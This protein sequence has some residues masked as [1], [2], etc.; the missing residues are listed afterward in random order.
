MQS[1]GYLEVYN[2]ESARSSRV[3]ASC[4]YSQSTRIEDRQKGTGETKRQQLFQ[5][6]HRL[7]LEPALDAALCNEVLA[8]RVSFVV[9]VVLKRSIS[10]PRRNEGVQ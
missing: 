8:R 9:T 3:T 4:T 1:I 10:H 2:V 7:S 5:V 6:W